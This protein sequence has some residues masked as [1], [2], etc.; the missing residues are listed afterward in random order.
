MSATDR[1]QKLLA[2]ADMVSKASQTI[3][4]E[5]AK[6]PPQ[7]AKESPGT[8]L[9]SWELYQA[10]RTIVAACGAFLDLVQNPSM[11][12]LEMSYGFLESRSIH[13]VAEHRI[14]DVLARLDPTNRVGVHIDTLSANVGINASKLGTWYFLSVTAVG[15]S[16]TP[17]ARVM[18]ILTSNHVFAEISPDHFTNN[19]ASSTL[20]GDEAFR[21][22]FMFQYVEC[23][24][25]EW[26]HA[27]TVAAQRIPLDLW[28]FTLP[29]R[30]SQISSVIL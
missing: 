23:S 21:A 16:H 20:I 1:S 22:L 10:E 12:L 19:S 13:V 9:P 18:R 27:R 4:E 29:A 6:E 17:S 3:V 28:T 7:T 14:S 11:R 24:T 5:W 15:N 30:S 2:L 26:Y 25:F 8:R